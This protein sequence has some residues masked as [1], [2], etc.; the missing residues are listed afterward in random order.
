MISVG[1]PWVLAGF[2]SWHLGFKSQSEG[3]GFRFVVLLHLLGQAK[4]LKRGQL[5]CYCQLEIVF[6]FLT[7][8]VFVYFPHTFSC[9]GYFNHQLS[10]VF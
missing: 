1:R 10:V 6:A 9:F 4:G 2:E 3:N 5:P 7:P 8:T